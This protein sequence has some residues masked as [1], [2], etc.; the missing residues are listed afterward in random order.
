MASQAQVDDRAVKCAVDDVIDRVLDFDDDTRRRVF[1]TAETFLFGTGSGSVFP[2]AQPR[3]EGPGARSVR[4]T[5]FTDSDELPPKDFLFQK[6]PKTDIE[7]V[8]CL[9]YYLTHYRE[10]PHFKTV[11]ISLLNTEAAQIKFSNAAYAVTNATNA[12]LL[13][14]AGKGAKQLSAQGERF[15]EALPD[16]AAAKEI[17]ASIRA[18]R[19]RAKSSKNKRKSAK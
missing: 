3:A 9:A 11:D 8:A 7:R 6:R 12:G 5:S 4:G 16:R 14:P 18:R 13:A 2:V 10:T 19:S 15:V 1:R 17:Q